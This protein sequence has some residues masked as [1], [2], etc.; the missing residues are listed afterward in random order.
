MYPV[1]VQYGGE[2]VRD[3]DDGS[4]G[5]LLANGSLEARF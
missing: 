1:S 3:G 2:P 4:V 5:K